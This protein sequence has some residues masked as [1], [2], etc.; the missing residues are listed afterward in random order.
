MPLSPRDINSQ[1]F[2]K[3]LFGYKK[4]DV[5]FFMKNIAQG[6]DD[7]R[8]ELD[9]LRLELA[10]SD[11]RVEKLK[12]YS[13]SVKETLELAREKAD[14]IVNKGKETAESMVERAEEEAQSIM[15]G[16]QKEINRR[17]SVLFE[18][19]EVARGYRK[20]FERMIQLSLRN[21]DDFEESLEHRQADKIRD[22]ISIMD[23]IENPVKEIDWAKSTANFRIRNQQ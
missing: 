18:I 21:M 22:S 1:T 20:K 23:R 16:Y 6:V 9:H 8:R 12:E 2:S 14:H 7:M 17:K 3:T 10:E 5:D 19:T 15:I 11:K 13:H 4:D